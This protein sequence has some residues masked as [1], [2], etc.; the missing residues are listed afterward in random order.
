M[1][2]SALN[3]KRSFAARILRDLPDA[4]AST[5]C[6]FAPQ[7]DK[8]AAIGGQQI[9]ATFSSDSGGKNVFNH[10]RGL[11]Q[12]YP[13][14]IMPIDGRQEPSVVNKCLYAATCWTSGTTWAATNG[15]SVDSGATG[16]RAA[17]NYATFTATAGN[18]TLLQTITATAAAHVMSFW[19]RRRTGSG[20]VQLTADGSTWATVTVTTDWTR[21]WVQQTASAAGINVGMRLVTNG[22]AVDVDLAQYE[23]GTFPTSNIITV[24]GTVTRAADAL[25]IINSSVFGRCAARGALLL[26]YQPPYPGN[27]GLANHNFVG[28]NNSNVLTTNS[29]YLQDDDYIYAHQYSGGGYQGNLRATSFGFWSAETIIAALV[30]WDTGSRKLYVNGT[31]QTSDTA[32]PPAALDRLEIGGAISSNP[33]GG[34]ANYLALV[35]SRQPSDSESKI[36]TGTNFRNAVKYGA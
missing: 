1:L 24:A 8:Y 14:N 3:P 35:M 19:V 30:S 28:L 32:T 13:T 36:L 12:N 10:R 23:L 9:A 27:Y 16:I 17:N 26:I 4:L 34:P 21:V 29:I 6:I 31:L 18:A 22:D 2:K 15:T 11:I 5:E 20:N 7:W 25:R 33:R